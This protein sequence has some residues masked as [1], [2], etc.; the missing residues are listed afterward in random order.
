MK[1]KCM[2]FN[3]LASVWVKHE[4][5]LKKTTRNSPKDLYRLNRIAKNLKV[6]KKEN[7][8]VIFLQ[9]AT[10]SM[11]NIL[12]KEIPE[13]HLC[14]AENFWKTTPTTTTKQ[15]AIHPSSNGNAILYKKQ[16]FLY[17]KCKKV[18]LDSKTGNYACIANA[19]LNNGLNIKLVCVHLAWNNPKLASS[20]F[21]RL[22]DKSYT[23]SYI[24]DEQDKYVV[25]AGDFNMGDFNILTYPILKD[26]KKHNFID[27]FNGL[28][29]HPFTTDYYKTYSHILTRNINVKNIKAG[30]SKSV[31][32]CIQK[33]GSDHYPIVIDL[34]IK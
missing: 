28:R 20:Q 25:I 31:L 9:E 8:D 6:L 27:P 12:K 1:L 23:N 26:I 11:L 16:K 22:F 5:E 4:T 14:Y 15:Q 33:Y 3:V 29:T 30:T 17:I 2:S 21:R 18:S 10:P 13:Y 24:N 7:P 19:I 34:I 32:E